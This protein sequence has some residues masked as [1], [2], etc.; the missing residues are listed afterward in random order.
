[1]RVRGVG[2][3]FSSERGMMGVGERQLVMVVVVVGRATSMGRMG[4]LVARSMVEGRPSVA[5]QWMSQV[6]RMSQTLRRRWISHWFWRM[7]SAVAEGG[8]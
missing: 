2:G 8:G 5:P 6:T 3:S 1:M 7:A 4:G